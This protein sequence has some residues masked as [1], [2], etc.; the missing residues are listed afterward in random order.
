MDQITYESRYLEQVQNLQEYSLR[1]SS[2]FYADSLSITLDSNKFGVKSKDFERISTSDDYDIDGFEILQPV[3]YTIKDCHIH[4][5]YGILTIDKYVILESTSHFPNYYYEGRIF[6]DE[7]S[8][9]WILENKSPDYMIDYAI[10]CHHGINLN[11]Y[12]WL[13][14]FLPKLHPKMID[15]VLEQSHGKMPTIIFPPLTDSFH[16]ESVEAITKILAMPYVVPDLC[17]HISVNTLIYP[18]PERSIGLTP[19]PLVREMLLL[20]RHEL[21]DPSYDHFEKIFI[22]RRDTKNRIISNEHDIATALESR[23]FQVV[24]LTSMSLREQI[25]IFSNARFVV[26]QHGA[27]LTNIGF[28]NEGTKIL[29]LH[30]PSYQNWCYRRLSAISNLDYG[31]IFGIE[32]PAETST[33][34]SNLVMTIDIELLLATIDEME[35]S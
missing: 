10:S 11:Y 20:L 33:H 4:T 25:T 12:H 15:T 2:T 9:R 17:D 19:H 1:I 27:G 31:F 3:F 32:S 35:S 34:T 7:H 13:I 16:I 28:C 30:N 6:V 14:L 18:I 23:G 8:K 5:C 24:T 26:G 21:L 29:E 22:S